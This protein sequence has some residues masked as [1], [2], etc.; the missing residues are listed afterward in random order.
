MTK[1]G[2]CHVFRSFVSVGDSKSSSSVF[3]LWAYTSSRTRFCHVFK[4]LVRVDSSRDSS[5]V[6]DF[7][8]RV[9]SRYNSGDLDR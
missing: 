6:S 4:S 8:I 5:S 9:S 3:G 7:L 2:F 1:A